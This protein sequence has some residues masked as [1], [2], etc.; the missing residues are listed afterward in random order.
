MLLLSVFPLKHG[1]GSL[2]H[3]NGRFFLFDQQGFKEVSL[4]FNYQF[5]SE[6]CLMILFPDP[7]LM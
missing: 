4:G 3:G 5:T 2:L 6:L 1:M 7:L